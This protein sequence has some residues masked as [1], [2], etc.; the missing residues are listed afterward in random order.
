MACGIGDLDPR[1][2]ATSRLVSVVEGTEQGERIAA[3]IAGLVGLGGSGLGPEETFWAIRRFFEAHAGDRP[4]VLVL[5]D[6]Q[7]GESTLIDMLEYLMDFSTGF[8]WLFVCLARTE[9][10]EIRPSWGAGRP[11]ASSITLEPLT[12]AD[13]ERLLK[14]LLGTDELAAGVAARIS[15]AS[16]GNP[17]FAQEML[18]MLVDD[19][20][21]VKED[22]G[23]APTG[24]LSSFDVPPTI[25]A[26]LAA[27]LERLETDERSVVQRASVVGKVFQWNAVAA[28]SPEPARAVVG[29]NLQTL[30]R[31]ELIRP[32]TV[33][34]VGE[35]AFRFTHLLIR[36]AAYGSTPKHQRAQ[37]HRRFADWLEARS[38]ES[39]IEYDEICGYHLEQAYRYTKELGT[40]SDDDLAI[41]RR[42][43]ELLARSGLRARSRGDAAAAVRLLDRAIALTSEE[44]DRVEWQLHLLQGLRQSGEG[45]RAKATLAEIEATAARTGDRRLR[46]HVEVHRRM[47]DEFPPD[48]QEREA[49]RLI[50]EFE[51]LGDDAGLAKAWTMFA[52]ALDDRGLEMPVE[53]YQRSID[54]ARRAG[55]TTIAH[56][57]IANMCNGYE[58]GPMPVPDRDRAVRTGARRGRRRAVPGV[59]DPPASRR[60]R[61]DGRSV[62][63][64]AP[65][66]QAFRGDPAGARSAAVRRC[67]APTARRRGAVGRQLRGCRG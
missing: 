44:G 6:I 1:D 33:S 9:L 42:G 26:L 23:W 22:R 29:R 60:S 18:R 59:R 57:G 54:H 35:D 32:D 3:G 61:G 50:D 25:N 16:G 55:E 64:S 49:R 67:L 21:L 62:R 4:L 36:D 65:A 37:L 2:V 39:D 5:D 48:E 43:A 52:F 10:M 14:E 46:A 34:F 8:P 15:D 53:A 63:R 41:A 12:D 38:D 58:S 20:L 56:M 27:R 51:E 17:L 13:S 47:W 28:L 66:Q 40:A 30:V 7:W 24:D 31:K 11:N 19:G 45:E